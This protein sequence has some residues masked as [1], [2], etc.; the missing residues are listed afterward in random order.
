MVARLNFTMLL[1]NVMI[2]LNA[3]MLILILNAYMC[4][5]LFLGMSFKAKKVTYLYNY[6]STFQRKK[7]HFFCK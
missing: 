7:K 2:F 3:A 5:K 1:L 6:G 4:L